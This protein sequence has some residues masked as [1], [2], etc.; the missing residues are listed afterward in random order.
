MSQIWSYWSDQAFGY[1][2][3]VLVMSYKN[4]SMKLP[5]DVEAI[6]VQK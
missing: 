5:N 3:G 1:I 4:L 6:P 2:Y